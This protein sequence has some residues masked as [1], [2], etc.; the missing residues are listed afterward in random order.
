MKKKTGWLMAGWF[1]LV[2]SSGFH[3]PVKHKIT[4]HFTHRIGSGELLLLDKK[5]VNPFGEDMVIAKFKYYISNMVLTGDNGKSV[6]IEGPPW[7]IDEADSSSKNIHILSPLVRITAIQFQVGIDSIKNVSGVQTG[8]LDPLKGMFWTWNTGYIFAKLEGYSDTAKVP[9]HYFTYDI[10]GYKKREN[11]IRKIRLA[12]P[13]SQSGQEYPS[14]ISIDADINKWFLS[15]YEINISHSPI[16]HSPGELAMK[17]A[18]NYS[19]MFS[20]G[21]FK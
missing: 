1:L 12:L 16:C 15:K 17:I 10:G 6:S 8:A 11:A 2:G 7:L 5:Y 13:A 4:I 14:L 3:S 9:G 18:D 19:D 21:R 20:I